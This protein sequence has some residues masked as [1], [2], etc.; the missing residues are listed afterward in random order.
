MFIIS[1][2][3][4]GGGGLLDMYVPFIFVKQWVQSATTAVTTDGGSVTR[5]VAM[6]LCKD[7]EEEEL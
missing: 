4:S 3:F 1:G 6:C 5:S 7:E 2:G